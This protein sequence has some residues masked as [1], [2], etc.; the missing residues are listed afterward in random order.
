MKKYICIHGHFYQPP[1][2]N[3]WLE[4]I[5]IQDSAFPYHD[6][7]ERI[8]AECYAPNAASRIL[9]GQGEI[10]DIVNNYQKISFNFGPT[11]LSWIK[12][13]IPK[14]LKALCDADHKSMQQFN[15]HGSAIAQAYNHM[16]L[17][18]SN[19]RDKY[20]QIYWG[21]RDFE[22]VFQHKPEGLWLPETAVDIESLDIMAKLGIRFTILAPNQAKSIRKIG[23]SDWHDVTGAKIDTR[24]AYLL[25]LPSGQSITLFFYDG[26]VS[27]DVA[28][29]KLLDKGE[30][31]ANRLLSLF[32]K[33]KVDQLVHIATDGETYGH[34][35]AHGDMALAYAINHIEST[36]AAEIMIYGCFLELNPPSYEVEIYENSSWSCAHG[37]ERWKNDCGCN[38]GMHPGWNQKW[39][40]PLREALDWLRDTLIPLYEENVIKYVND[41]WMT[42]NNY[43]EIIHDRSPE[44]IENF[45]QKNANHDLNKQEKQDLLKWLELQRHALLMYTS[46]GWFFDELSGIETSQVILYAGRVIQLAKDLLNTDFET[47]FLEKISLAKSNIPQ[48]D[49]GATI[50]KLFVKP[51][52]IDLSNVAAHFAISSLYKAYGDETQIFCYNIKNL[53]QNSYESGKVKL[54]LGQVF[55][56]SNITLEEAHLNYG[57]IHFGDQNLNCSVKYFSNEEDFSL[58]ET[59]ITNIFSRGEI[60]NVVK[61]FEKFFGPETYS[62]RNLFRDEQRNII[63]KILEATLLESDA[64]YRQL[65]DH[66]SPMIDFLVDINIPIPRELKMVA[67]YSIKTEIKQLLRKKAVNYEKIITL[68]DKLKK[69]SISLDQNEIELLLK[70]KIQK[71][72]MNFKAN[73]KNIRTMNRLINLITFL[74]ITGFRLDLWKAQ[75]IVFS[76]AKKIDVNTEDSKWLAQF[77]KLCAN[78]HVKVQRQ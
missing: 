46:C 31:F 7:N 37:I 8:T 69:L 72:V 59:E 16:I 51:N 33:D 56:S 55:V 65:Y 75:N 61:L 11:L 15:S 62:I 30:T 47:P 23:D 39:R 66:Y 5:E 14:L 70:M 49:N 57:V 52:Q 43:I 74:N 73:Y 29:E 9:D 42:R 1:R 25:K 40:A 28:F 34:H 36:K 18:L 10:I 4:T 50:Y 77:D 53:K 67:E 64:A 19:F 22:F 12:I 38:S 27:K 68:I 41:P 63:N 2:E 13:K 32:S 76:V 60:I 20:T 44:V 6:W 45:F 21:I 78:L 24:H 17:P 48:L 54:I 26:P 35:H 58:A 71:F 3:P